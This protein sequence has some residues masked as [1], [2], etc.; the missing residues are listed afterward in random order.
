MLPSEEED[1]LPEEDILKENWKSNKT[2]FSKRID[3]LTKVYFESTWEFLINP[4]GY[5][6]VT[7][8]IM[9]Q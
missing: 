6:Q 9:K 8:D 1:V 5:V 2:N 3:K 4:H 7:K